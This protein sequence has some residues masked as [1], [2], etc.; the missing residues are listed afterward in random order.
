MSQ[1][2]I[3]IFLLEGHFKSILETFIYASILLFFI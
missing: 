3:F 2:L 1:G